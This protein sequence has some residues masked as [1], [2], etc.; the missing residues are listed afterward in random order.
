MKRTILVKRYNILLIP[1]EWK[2]EIHLDFRITLKKGPLDHDK[3]FNRTFSN[4]CRDTGFLLQEKLISE[5]NLS[6][7]DCFI[8]E[9]A[10]EKEY[11]F[12]IF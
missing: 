1:S 11:Q 10:V 2:R 4:K 12:L 9:C 6:G 3:G 7:N 5:I 8:I